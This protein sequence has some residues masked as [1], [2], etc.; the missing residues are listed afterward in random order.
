MQNYQA[1]NKDLKHK[2]KAYNDELMKMQNSMM[3]KLQEKKPL[4]N[5]E[6]ILEN[7]KILQNFSVYFLKNKNKNNFKINCLRSKR[8]LITPHIKA[9]FIQEHLIILMNQLIIYLECR[10]A[11]PSTTQHVLIQKNRI[12]VFNT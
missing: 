3:M 9:L 6:K 11:Q 1:L 4:T 12:I 7:L 10:Q 5:E 8:T 2:K